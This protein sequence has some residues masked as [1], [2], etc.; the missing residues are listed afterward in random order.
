MRRIFLAALV[1]GGVILTSISFAATY[2]G[3]SGTSI[4][5]YQIWTPEQMNTIG[6]NST[7]WNKHFILMVDID[8]SAYTGTQYK[9]IGNATTRFSGNFNGNNHKI[10]NLTFTTTANVDY[11]GLFGY[12]NNAIIKNLGIENIALYTGGKYVGGLAGYL[13][14][15]RNATVRVQ[16]L[17]TL[18]LFQ[19]LPSILLTVAAWWAGMT[20]VLLHTA[21]VQRRL[22]LL[23]LILT[24]A[25]WWDGKPQVLLSAIA[26][27]QVQLLL[28]LYIHPVLGAS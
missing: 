11:V 6:A 9:I 1:V 23:T 5:P 12:A 26:I 7:D 28:R 18:Q 10:S 19:L 14:L 17:L 24:V 13:A 20:Q 2:G 16:L 22:P 25:D 27:A 15:L 3:G 21:T 4:D 8:M